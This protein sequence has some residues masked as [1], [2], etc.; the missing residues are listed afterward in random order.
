MRSVSTYLLVDDGLPATV[1]SKIG[2]RSLAPSLS[3]PVR[4]GSV[5]RRGLRRDTVLCDKRALLIVGS[6]RDQA[7]APTAPRSS[8]PPCRR[9]PQGLGMTRLEADQVLELLR[10]ESLLATRP[11]VPFV[12]TGR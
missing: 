8:V 2:V 4:F 6:Y 9:I 12:L 1:I 11:I 7:L 5:K 3:F 10:S